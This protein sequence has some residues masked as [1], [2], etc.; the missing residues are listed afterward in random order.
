MCIRDSLSRIL[1]SLIGWKSIG[2]SN[3]YMF[4]I[5]LLY[6]LTYVAFKVTKKQDVYKRQIRI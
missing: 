6:V 1:L 5:L 3:W 2:N 4:D